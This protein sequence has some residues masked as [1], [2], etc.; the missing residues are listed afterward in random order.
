[1]IHVQNTATL[2][3]RQAMTR[4]RSVRFEDELEPLVCSTSHGLQICYYEVLFCGGASVGIASIENETLKRSYGRGSESH[5]GWRRVSYGFHSDD[6]KIYW[7]ATGW[8]YRCEEF[9]KPWNKVARIGCGYDRLRRKL[10][11]TADGRFVG[12][13]NFDVQPSKYAAVLSLHQHG[14]SATVNF[15]SAPFAFDIE[16]YCCIA[17]NSVSRIRCFARRGSTWEKV[18]H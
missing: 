8:N 15:G 6:G 16:T 13:A 9:C 7:N 11:F 4:T 10:F 5:V 17:G 2:P 12:E 1:M 14:N 18:S 3:W